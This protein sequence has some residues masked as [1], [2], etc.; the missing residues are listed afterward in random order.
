M[1]HCVETRTMHKTHRFCPMGHA[2]DG[3]IALLLN[4]TL[5]TFGSASI[6]ISNLDRPVDEG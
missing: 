5:Y 1:V 6:I 4:A 3:R 2:T